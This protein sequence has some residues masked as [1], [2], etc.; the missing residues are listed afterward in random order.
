LSA[1]GAEPSTTRKRRTS[2]LVEPPALVVVSL[3]AVR[4]L[5]LVLTV[6]ADHSRPVTDDDVLRFDQIAMTHGTP[7]RDF[8]VEYMPVEMA[9]IHAIARDGPASTAT[10][11]A[12]ISFICDLATAG[13]LWYGW[14]KGAAAFYLLLGLPL[15]TF[16]LYRVDPLVVA[17][18]A[19]SM[20]L[21][22]RDRDGP[23]GVLLALAVLTKIWPLVLLPWFIYERRTRALMTSAAVAG[24]GLVAWVI[25]G[26]IRAPWQVLTFRG[27]PGWEV[28]SLI[29]HLVWLIKGS[30]VHLEAGAA[31]IG[32]APLWARALLLAA[33]IGAVTWIWARTRKGV[34]AAGAPAMAAVTALLLCSPLFSVQYTA[35]L[36]P[37]AAVAAL[38][39][40]KE[41]T[42]AGFA[43]AAICIGGALAVLYGNATP[44]SLTW[45]KGLLLIRNALCVGMLVY[46]FNANRRSAAAEVVAEPTA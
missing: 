4:I 26:G 32:V 10:R 11:L 46:W 28:E 24:A 45:I 9:T 21:A 33:A 25:V 13:A 14:G 39:A 5:L 6:Q 31:R 41:R 1:M 16:I 3:I 15:Q 44:G 43:F 18:A 35:W 40:R 2:L 12:L 38:G 34:E 17:L 8:Q 7:Y 42:M 22:K 19:W 36:V 20:A 29:G 37:W 27:A 23:S 30:P